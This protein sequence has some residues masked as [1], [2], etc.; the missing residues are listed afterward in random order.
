MKKKIL[1]CTLA[2]MLLFG[3][4]T[5]SIFATDKADVVSKKPTVNNEQISL[6]EKDS[7]ELNDLEAEKMDMFIEEFDAQLDFKNNEISTDDVN[8][9]YFK[10]KYGN[11]AVQFATESINK[12]NKLAN[13]GNIKISSNGTISDTAETTE[14]SP[15]AKAKN[16]LNINKTTTH[17][18]GRTIYLSYKNANKLKAD[19][20][21]TSSRTAVMQLIAGTLNKFVGSGFGAVSLYTD[22]FCKR[23]SACNKK[24]KGIKYKLYW[25]MKFKMRTQGAA[26]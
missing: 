10:E 8:L 22:Y 6:D 25:V 26:W 24:N 1:T 11:Q 23:I 17:W 5:S 13:E 4:T 14:I 20:K 15:F 19:L 18:W 9:N 16:K 3:C 21:K 12:T 7:Y 2:T